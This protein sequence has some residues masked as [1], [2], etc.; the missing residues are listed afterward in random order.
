MKSVI[1]KLTE[2]FLCVCLSSFVAFSP[3]AILDTEKEKF[4]QVFLNPAIDDGEK[5]EVELK[6]L[7][8]GGIC[9][10]FAEI[11]YDDGALL[12]L[13]GASECSLEFSS[14]D[15]GGAVRILL[16]GVENCENECVLARLFFCR[17]GS[18]ESKLEI[19]GAGENSVLYLNCNNETETREIA[20]FGCDIGKGSPITDSE[21]VARLTF[22]EVKDHGGEFVISFEVS[23]FQG[24]FAAGVRFFIV[25]LEGGGCE[26][27]SVLGVIGEENLYK[28]EYHISAK[29]NSAA[30][31]TA[32][33]YDR[34][35][36]HTGECIIEVLN[37][38]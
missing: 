4:D 25:D 17:T 24:C 10:L 19:F 1:F 35:G 6:L 18:G 8:D 20:F 32:F 37:K 27:V 23:G 29:V 38:Y 11:K 34:F 36:E 21:K 28:G 13:G 14:V 26:D 5:L 7:S 2:Y 31:I 9:A 33:G 12:Y 22:F 16:D 3:K 15:M 30:V